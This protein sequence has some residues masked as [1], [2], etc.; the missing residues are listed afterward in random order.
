MSYSV[1]KAE[2]SMRRGGGEG[3]VFFSSCCAH[4][5]CILLLCIFQGPSGHDV[6]IQNQDGAFG[7]QSPVLSS[8]GEQECL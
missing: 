3:R 7:L 6:Y 1:Y 8:G 5:L 4:V 2:D